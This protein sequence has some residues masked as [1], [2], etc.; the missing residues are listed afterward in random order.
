[1]RIGEAVRGHLSI[2]IWPISWSNW[3]N[4]KTCHTISVLGFN[5]IFS[6]TLRSLN[7]SLSTEVFQLALCML[8]CPASVTLL[9]L[10]TLTE[11]VKAKQL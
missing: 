8:L 11:Q 5:I 9:D 4:M 3:I 7:C 6:S 10:M 1:M 2:S